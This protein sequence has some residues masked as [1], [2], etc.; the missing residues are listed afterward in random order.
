MVHSSKCGGRQ[1]IHGLVSSSF[2]IDLQNWDKFCSSAVC[3]KYWK[4]SQL[5]LNSILLVAKLLTLIK[6][7]RF[8]FL[9]SDNCCWA[10]WPWTC[11]CGSVSPVFVCFLLL[12][13]YFILYLYLYCICVMLSDL[14]LGQ[15]CLPLFVA[16]QTALFKNQCFHHWST[17]FC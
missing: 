6:T 10:F 12:Y 13:L 9:L 7:F 4:T 14:N 3:S 5:Y 11:T 16:E 2:C 1:I 8:F 15:Y 17:S